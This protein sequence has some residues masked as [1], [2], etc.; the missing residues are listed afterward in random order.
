MPEEAAGAMRLLA[1][2][3]WP[4]L[5]VAMLLALSVAYRYGPC[6]R[7]AKWRWVTWGAAVS[8]TIWVAASSLLAYYA[9]HRTV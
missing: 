9:A 5:I 3:R 1:P 2:S 4:V 6:R 7:V 8:A